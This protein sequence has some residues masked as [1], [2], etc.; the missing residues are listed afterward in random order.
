MPI[1]GTITNQDPKTL[2]R[3]SEFHGVAAPLLQTA[4]QGSKGGWIATGRISDAGHGSVDRWVKRVLVRG[5]TPA[6]VAN[7]FAYQIRLEAGIDIDRTI[8]K[9]LRAA[10]LPVSVLDWALRTGRNMSSATRQTATMCSASRWWSTCRKGSACT[11]S[12]PASFAAP[13]TRSPEADSTVVPREHIG[14][15]FASF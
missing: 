14:Y 9:N 2:V 1:V 6:G 11:R 7:V 8:G 10:I 5:V 13:T 4:K 3:L 12:T 15:L